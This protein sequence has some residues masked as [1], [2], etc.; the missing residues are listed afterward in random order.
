MMEG[1]SGRRKFD[2]EFK[3]EAVRQVVDGGRSVAE[4][5]RS[6]GIHE[7]L[8]HKWKKQLKEDSEGALPGRGRLKPQEG[9]LR[10]LQRENASLE[11]DREIL[12]SRWPSSQN[13]ADE[14]RVHGKRALQVRGGEDVPAF[15][16]NK[17]R[18]LRLVERKEH[19][20]AAQG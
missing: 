2:S 13:A 15:W 18:L 19:R 3:R 8:L 17:E 14:L 1:G 7:M 11:E 4:V 5:A 16:C 9:E 6:L 10:R 20:K 12:K